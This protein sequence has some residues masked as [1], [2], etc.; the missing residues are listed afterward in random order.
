[1]PTMCLFIRYLL[2]AN[3]CAC[4]E[5]KDTKALGTKITCSVHL[6]CVFENGIQ[7]QLLCFA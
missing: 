5:D 2:C 7:S 6:I 1:M 3:H 4:A